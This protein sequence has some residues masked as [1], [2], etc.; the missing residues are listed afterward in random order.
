MVINP[1]PGDF[2]TPGNP[3]ALVW[4]SEIDE[5]AVVTAVREGFRIDNERDLAQDAG[6]GIRQLADIALRA[7]SPGVND[8]TTALNCI[9]YLQ[10]ILERLVVRDF[11]G[12]IRKNEETGVTVIARHRS[13]DEYIADAFIEVGRYSTTDA[14]VAVAL[15]DAIGSIQR[16]ANSVGATD[17]AASAK[18]AAEN[19][20]RPAIEAA[21]SAYDGTLIKEHLARVGVV[22]T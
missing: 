15:I 11:P 5:D 8:P 10:A 1:A 17:R 7:L 3:I 9:G 12:A 4:G 6:Y 22:V 2:V 19:I 16:L 14:R 18:N 13:F 20:G 21:K